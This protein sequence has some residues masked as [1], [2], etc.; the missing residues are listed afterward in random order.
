MPYCHFFLSV[1]CHFWIKV[2]DSLKKKNHTHPKL[3]NGSKQMVKKIVKLLQI[4]CDEEKN[5]CVKFL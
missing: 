2:S 4:F 5:I 1:F 3:F